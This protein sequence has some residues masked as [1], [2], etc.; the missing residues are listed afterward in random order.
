MAQDKPGFGE[1]SAARLMRLIGLPDAPVILDLCLPEDVAQAPYRI[2]T[3]SPASHR[4]LPPL[5][6]TLQGR[7]VVVVCQRGKK[8]SHGAAALL[9]AQ[10]IPAEV[11]VGGMAGWLEAS[12]PHT[13]LDRLPGS[14]RWVTRHRPKIDRIA[15]PWLIRRF[16]DP[17]ATVLFVP[18]AEVAAVADRFDAIPFDIPDVPFSHHGDGCTFDTLLSHFELATPALLHLADIV[19][20][21]DTDRLDAA[22]QAAGLLAVSVGLS[23]MFKDDQVQLDAGLLVYDALYRWARDG[24]DETHD[25][26]EEAAR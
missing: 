13:P 15:C 4:D 22:P 12:Y 3:A 20:A 8:I 1:I 5:L 10:G 24:L 6:P 17:Q 26:E 14:A 11:L 9:R 18:P 2:P 21:A 16:V 19:R 23:R 25:W 7:T